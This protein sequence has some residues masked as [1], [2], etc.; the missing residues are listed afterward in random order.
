MSMIMK[1]CGAAG[2]ARIEIALN[3]GYG[4]SLGG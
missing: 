3:Q 1:F 4:V 2:G